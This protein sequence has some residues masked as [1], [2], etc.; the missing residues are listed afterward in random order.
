[1]SAT[2]S[3][4]TSLSRASACLKIADE[5]IGDAYCFVAIE[6]NTKL[7]LNFALGRRNQA[8]T[9]IFIE[10][11]R[12]ATRGNFQITTDGFAPYRSAIANTLEDRCD[13]AML[14][15]VYRAAS[16]GEARYSPAEVA[17]TERTT[18]SLNQHHCALANIETRF[19]RNWGEAQMADRIQREGCRLQRQPG[20]NT[21]A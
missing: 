11:L 8:T 20:Q 2:K 17:S 5:S 13:F 7:V 10:G 19:R 14:I 15:K 16:E 3:G 18:V 4:A 9:D 6:R 12:H 1:M 21:R